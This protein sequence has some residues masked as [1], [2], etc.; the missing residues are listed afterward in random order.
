MKWSVGITLYPDGAYFETEMHLF[1]RTAFPHRYWFWAN[2]AAPQ[3]EGLEFISTTTK[4]MSLNGLWD[5]PIH[6]G[7]DVHWERNHLAPQDMFCLNPVQEFVGWYNHDLDRGL[8]NVADR[9][10][11]RGTKFYTWGNSDDGEVWVD[12]L[13]ESD[14]QYAEMQSGRFQTM[15]IW[16][17][18]PPYTVE[19]WKE[20]WYP[21]RRIGTPCFANRE[22][23]F[24]LNQAEG[25]ATLNLQVNSPQPKSEVRLSSGD[26]VWWHDTTDLDPGAPYT[27][28]IPAVNEDAIRLT[29]LSSSGD[30]LAE[31]D[32]N[33]AAKP[34]P[35]IKSYLKIDPSREPTG[36][37]SC[38]LNGTDHEKLGNDEQARA[39]HKEALKIDPGYSPALIALGILDLKEG[40]L[41][42]AEERFKK[43][44]ERNP[45]DDGAHFYLGVCHLMN[46]EVG[47]AIEELNLLMRSK[48]YRSGSAYLLGGLYLGRGNL[49]KAEEQLQ[50]AA[51]ENADA[52]AMLA[53]VQR[54][55]QKPERAR[56]VIRAVLAEDALNALA[57]AEDYFL[58]DGNGPDRTE[59]KQALQISLRNEVQSYLELALEYGRF[60]LYREAIDILTLYGEASSERR[61]YPLV[62]YYLGYYTEK[63]GAG[64]ADEHYRAGSL[65]DPNF[66][67]PYRLETERLLR[68]VIKQLPEDRYAKYYLGNLLCARNRTEEAILLW[69]AA[70]VGETQ[71]SVVH[72]NLGRAYWKV[73]E[74]GDKAVKAYQLALQCDPE[75]YKLYYE[76][77]KIYVSLDLTEKRAELMASIPASLKDNDVVSERIAIYLV[78]TGDFDG[79]L[80]LLKGRYFFPWEVYKGVRTLYVDALV[81]RGCTLMKTGKAQ[82][83]MESY[84]EA[85]NYP[86]NIGVGEPLLKTNAEVL[87]RIGLAYEQEG[88]GAEAHSHWEQA[89]SE[90]RPVCS[91]LCYYQAEALKKLGRGHEADQA[92]DALEELAVGNLKLQ[93]A[94]AAQNNYLLGL[95]CKGK[96]DND[97]AR[98][99][100]QKACK[101]DPGHRRSR[102]EAEGFL[103]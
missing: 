14:G 77:D 2:S 103:D 99:C 96:G 17:I 7:M 87:Y 24:F 94:D 54:R 57:R 31:Y 51:A 97:R 15:A 10:E 81:A 43:A 34:A 33:S 70:A 85:C 95:A 21:L 84:R 39:A 55:A 63:L 28:Q 88:K 12:R 53:C 80:K 6:E 91:E 50:K 101:L 68:R 32:L 56:D 11:A 23:A 78:D 26:R 3:S 35:A 42:Q 76:L 41:S 58:A 4:I 82:K 38:C 86:R 90:K 25:G 18:L 48:V 100:F 60:G 64:G 40:R 27:A 19:S 44:L 62:H 46:E 8:V 93:D 89:A 16:E 98:S 36:A 102:W 47:S 30:L 74:D 52:S 69:E 72:R 92:L 1:N 75:D 67:F 71:V 65:A 5:F 59:K 13:T 29:V 66:V 20:V 73:L 61:D 45:G 49:G 83:A 22:V 9:S 79:A 37:Q